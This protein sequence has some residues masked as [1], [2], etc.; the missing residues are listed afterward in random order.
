[1]EVTKSDSTCTKANSVIVIKKLKQIVAEKV[2]KDFSLYLDEQ[3]S[4][5]LCNDVK[6]IMCQILLQQTFP[7]LSNDI[8]V[9]SREFAKHVK[10]LQ[11]LLSDRTEEIELS[12]LLSID[13]IEMRTEKHGEL[14][15][16]IA[17]HAPKIKSLTINEKRRLCPDNIDDAALEAICRL[18]SLQ[19]LEIKTRSILFTD[20]TKI[21]KSLRNLKYVNALTRLCH[22]QLRK[23]QIVGNPDIPLTYKSRCSETPE[24]RTLTVKPSKVQKH[25]QYTNITALKILWQEN[26]KKISSLPKFP[27]LKTLLL[28][29]FPRNDLVGQCLAE[30]GPQ[31]IELQ[32]KTTHHSL[33]PSLNINSFSSCLKLESLIMSNVELVAYSSVTTSFPQLKNFSWSLE[34]WVDT[35]LSCLAY[36]LSSPKLES[37]SCYWNDNIDLNHL[38]EVTT[39]IDE[40]KIKLS[41]LASFAFRVKLDWNTNLSREIFG[42]LIDAASTLLYIQKDGKKNG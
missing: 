19:K 22:R 28:I 17:D 23:L 6:E 15:K 34:K 16:L 1:M 14:M 21:C 10:I 29:H 7:M 38:T 8:A 39:L 12:S 41:H 31:L 42:V 37:F 35:K 24:L 4:G 25:M 2:A 27:F 32:I 40:Q 5:K 33:I 3:A 13:P 30:Y 26:S 18:H 9:N 11:L 20:L 36:I